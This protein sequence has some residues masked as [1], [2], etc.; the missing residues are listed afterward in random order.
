[1][2]GSYTYISDSSAFI[3]SIDKRKKYNLKNSS[4]SCSICGDPNHFAFGGGHDLTIWDNFTTNN[5]SKDYGY[6]HS[7]SMDEKYELTGGKN[8]FYV[9]ELEVYEIDFE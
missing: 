5:N 3:F 7:Y 8:S 6:N 2:T 1:M 4:C 9:K